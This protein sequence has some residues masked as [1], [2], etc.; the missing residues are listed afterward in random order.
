MQSKQPIKQ[1]SSKVIIK[2][3]TYLLTV[4]IY[5]GKN[6]SHIVQS[7]RKITSILFNNRKIRGTIQNRC[8]YYNTYRLYINQF[9]IEFA[10]PSGTVLHWE[11]LS[12]ASPSLGL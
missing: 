7:N 8:S 12:Y 9:I 6:E 11:G 5:V 3:I 2:T 4:F 1:F 10:K